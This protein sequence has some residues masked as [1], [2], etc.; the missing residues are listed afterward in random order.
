MLW[1]ALDVERDVELEVVRHFVRLENVEQNP[2]LVQEQPSYNRNNI[3]YNSRYSYA[4]SILA[5]LQFESNEN[6]VVANEFW[7]D[8]SGIYSPS[9]STWA[10]K[11]NLPYMSEGVLSDLINRYGEK[12]KGVVYVEMEHPDFDKLIVHEGD[13]Y[14][15]EVFAAKGK[16]VIYIRY[17]GNAPIN[18]IIEATA[19]K[20]KLIS[21]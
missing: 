9:I 7:K 21:E 12:Y 14:A 17:Q 8:G 11:I 5:P 19:E 20:I 2:E 3:D 18:S 4:W 13:Y 1:L 15:K 16:G 6:G 10:Y